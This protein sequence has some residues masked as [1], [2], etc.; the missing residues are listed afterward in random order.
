VHTANP[1]MP[2]ASPTPPPDRPLRKQSSSSS[3]DEYHVSSLMSNMSTA[4]TTAVLSLNNR[5][6]PM[7]S[8]GAMTPK[9]LHRFE[10]HAH[11]YLQNKDGLDAK[12]FV[13]HIIYSFEDPLFSDRYQLQQDLLSPSHSSI[14]C[15]GSELAGC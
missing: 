5:K 1:A 8:A 15:P 9:L 6:C 4:G 14:S 11:R 13:D 12:N 7:I 10:H 2:P 3:S